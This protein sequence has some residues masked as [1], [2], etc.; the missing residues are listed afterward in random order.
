MNE[1]KMKNPQ[2]YAIQLEGLTQSPSGTADTIRRDPIGFLEAYL[3][4]MENDSNRK[5]I[6]DFWDKYEQYKGIRM[7]DIDETIMR[8][9]I[10][11]YKALR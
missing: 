2:V 6:C 1:K 7:D 3:D 4:I 10:S 11:D 9:L 8:D 5:A